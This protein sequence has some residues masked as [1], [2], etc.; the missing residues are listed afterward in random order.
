MRKILFLLIIILSLTSCKRK[1]CTNP[2]AKNYDPKAKKED[3]SCVAYVDEMEGTYEITVTSYPRDPSQVGD[4]K[5]VL[6][7]KDHAGCNSNSFEDFNRIKFNNL[8][9]F[10]ECCGFPLNNKYY[11]NVTTEK[12]VAWCQA[13]VIGKGSIIQGVFHFEG[14]VSTSAGEFPIILDGYK[15]STSRRTDAC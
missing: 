8:F 2:Y 4:K 11:F 1:G 3:C 13:P 6:V 10:F 5:E 15:K 9:D 12:N 7:F 14:T